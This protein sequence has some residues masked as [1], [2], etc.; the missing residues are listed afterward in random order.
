MLIIVAIVCALVFAQN[1]LAAWNKT[2]YDGRI[3]HTDLPFGNAQ[4]TAGTFDDAV[5]FYAG[6]TLGVGAALAVDGIAAFAGF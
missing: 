3:L 6:A 2:V 1:L 4:G 5:V